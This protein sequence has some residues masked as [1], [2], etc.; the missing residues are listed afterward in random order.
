LRIDN[1]AYCP[2]CITTDQSEELTLGEILK[3]PSSEAGYCHMKFPPMRED[4]LSW[5]WPVLN[6]SARASID[7]Y[8]PCDHDPL[9]TDEIQTQRRVMLRGIFEDGE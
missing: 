9:G 6:E 8:G 1:E 3:V 5:T 2:G 7:F 4:S